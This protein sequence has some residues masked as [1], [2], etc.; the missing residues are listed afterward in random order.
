MDLPNAILNYIRGDEGR[1][2]KVVTSSF[3]LSV[4]ITLIP[5]AH[6]AHEN[7]RI[8]VWAPF[9]ELLQRNGPNDRKLS[10]L[11]GIKARI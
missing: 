11:L 1:A 7:S 2:L 10:D 9:H 8:A 6:A 4:A 5:A 3:A